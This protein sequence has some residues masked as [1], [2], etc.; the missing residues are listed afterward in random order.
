[1]NVV[2]YYIFKLRITKIK[3]KLKHTLKNRIKEKNHKNKKEEAY[4]D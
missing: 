2:E 3:Q 1:M 4:L